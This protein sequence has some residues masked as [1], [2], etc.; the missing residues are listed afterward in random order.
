[1][2]S[3]GL[4]LLILM[5]VFPD[6]ILG[7]S[8]YVDPAK[9]KEA[10]PGTKQAPIASF[11]EL[12]GKLS[13]GDIVY[14]AAGTYR[15]TVTLSA[16]GN[17]QQPIVIR[18][19]DQQQPIIKETTWTLLNASYVV[20]QG[21]TFEDCSPAILFGKGASDNIVRGKKLRASRFLQEGWM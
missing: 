16:R 19:V 3:K 17:A 12:S 11:Q 14:L 6:I 9:G 15:E 20:L 21:L 2:P 18:N 4:L 13:P 10:A 5:M 7:R 8:F 1:M